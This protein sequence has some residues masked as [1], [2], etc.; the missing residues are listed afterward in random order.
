MALLAQFLVAFGAAAAR[1]V[2]YAVEATHHHLNEFVILVGPSG[3]GRK[4]SSCVTD[5]GAADVS[6]DDVADAAR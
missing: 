3:K 6:L 2:H 5:L 1:N 4:G